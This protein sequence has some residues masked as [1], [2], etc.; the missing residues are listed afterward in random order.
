MKYCTHCGNELLDEAVICPKCGCPTNNNQGNLKDPN[1]NGFA[2]A[3]FVLSFFG[4]I[5]GIIFSAIGLKVSAQRNGAGKGL[6]IA[7]LIIGII[8]FVLY[9]ILFLTA[10]FS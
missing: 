10:L 9:F 2:I 1:S 6:A 3:G 7:G 4:G 5:L 8:S